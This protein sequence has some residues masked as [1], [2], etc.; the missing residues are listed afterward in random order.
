M[1]NP[2]S[3]AITV[4]DVIANSTEGDELSFEFKLFPFNDL[5]QP[6]REDDWDIFRGVLVALSF[7]D[8][9][10]YD[11]TG[12]GVIVGPGVALCAMHVVEDYLEDLVAGRKFL[13]AN[14]VA[15]GKHF[16]WSVSKLTPVPGTDLCALT[17]SLITEIPDHRIFYNAVLTTRAPSPGERV[18]VVGFRANAP[19][20]VDGKKITVDGSVIVSQGRVMD[21]YLERRDKWLNWPCFGIECMTWGGMSGGPVFD[22]RGFLIGMLCSSYENDTISFA[23][24]LW[25]AIV[26]PGP[27]S[28]PPCPEFEGKSLHERS[29]VNGAVIERPEALVAVDDGVYQYIYWAEKP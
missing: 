11:V 21:V 2:N 15:L 24:L 18:S 19:C 1:E 8:S 5:E 4:G 9:G 23:S 25:G 20:I 3:R 7:A 29:F 14:A 6:V 16:I 28:W 27:G 22:S 13:C 10:E 17:L 26:S 12:S